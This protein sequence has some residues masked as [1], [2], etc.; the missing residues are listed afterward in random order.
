MLITIGGQIAGKGL[1]VLILFFIMQE[2]RYFIFIWLPLISA[3]L[4]AQ[5]VVD[6]IERPY[7]VDAEAQNQA[8]SA[9][10]YAE[11]AYFYSRQAN[12]RNQLEDYRADIDTVLFYLKKSTELADSALLS[13]TPNDTIE[14][15]LNR[16]NQLLS[17]VDEVLRHIY[18]FRKL[19]VM[20]Q[21][22]EEVLTNLMNAK[23]DFYTASLYLSGGNLVLNDDFV[24][25]EL[26]LDQH[27]A[28]L[29]ADESAFTDLVLDLEERM[30]ELNERIEETRSKLSQATD[31][32]ERAA[33]EKEL[34]DLSAERGRLD[35]TLQ[36]ANDR[37][38][39]IRDQQQEQVKKQGLLSDADESNKNETSSDQF[40][41][42]KHGHYNDRQ[43]A[44]NEPLPEGLIYRV[45]LGYYFKADNNDAFHGLFPITGEDLKD[46]KIRY[47][48]GMFSSYT[49]AS[50]AKDYIREKRIG[51]AFVVP[52]LDGKKINVKRA[53]ELEREMHHSGQ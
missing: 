35:E 31:A 48:A 4:V 40:E 2:Y 11:E 33:L 12:S 22:S 47:Y 39:D 18:P 23:V 45:Q 38:Q 10:R 16:G 20:K 44:V 5:S 46:G 37:L 43:V 32:E 26:D 13:M 28:R 3:P 34:A 21:Y 6:Y 29:D 49:E 30:K 52:Y 53:I 17:E 19:P 8:L 9:A 50:K 27:L 51:D 14:A 25:E 24:Y 15:Y 36:K 41:T 7:Y 1:K 42:D